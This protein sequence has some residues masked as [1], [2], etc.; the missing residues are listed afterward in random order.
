VCTL[1][2]EP[3]GF[4]RLNSSPWTRHAVEAQ[5]GVERRRAHVT[6]KGVAGFPIDGDPLP[7]DD[8][9]A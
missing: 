8:E 4:E 2:G 3:I 5:E 6:P 7:K 9:A 1:S